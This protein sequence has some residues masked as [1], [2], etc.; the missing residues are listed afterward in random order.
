MKAK[1]EYRRCELCDKLIRVDVFNE[2]FFRNRT[3]HIHNGS[4]YCEPKQSR[5]DISG[6]YCNVDCLVGYLSKLPSVEIQ[7]IEKK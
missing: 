1:E 3:I 5:I 4:I 2:D 7:T 6:F